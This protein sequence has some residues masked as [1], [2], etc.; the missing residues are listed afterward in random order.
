MAAP[1]SLRHQIDRALLDFNHILL[2][3][4]NGFPP[5][6]GTDLQKEFARLLDRLRDILRRVRYPQ[7]RQWIQLSIGETEE[8]LVAYV[9][10]DD[11]KGSDLIQSAEE[12]F[13]AYLEG[14]KA[15]PTFIAGPNGQLEKA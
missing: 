6:E 3:A 11:K 15:S 8:A 1:H 4:P 5:E 10:G 13:K 7:A 14:K 9:S 12:H 2:C